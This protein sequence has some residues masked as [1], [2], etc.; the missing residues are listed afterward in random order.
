MAVSAIQETNTVVLIAS[1][2][3]QYY[4]V[5]LFTLIPIDSVHI[6]V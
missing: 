3:R 1:D 4:D 2:Q 6:E 5:I